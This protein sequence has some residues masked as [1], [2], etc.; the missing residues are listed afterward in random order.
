MGAFTETINLTP[1]AEKVTRTTRGSPPLGQRAVIAGGDRVFRWAQNGSVAL[2]V[3]RLLQESVIGSGHGGDLAVQAA[4]AI[5]DQTVSITNST[6][7]ITED[8]Y[9]FGYLWIDNEGHVYRIKSHPAE[10]TGSGTLVIT[11]EDDDFLRAALTTATS[12][13]GLRRNPYDEV[14]V[15]PTSPTGVPVGVTPV[16]VDA[17]AFFWAQSWGL[18]SVLTNGTP[19]VGLGVT[20]GASTAGSVD[21]QPLNSVNASGQE[22]LVGY[23][24]RVRA[25][26]EFSLIDLRI[27]P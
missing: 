21:V 20:A 25:T 24:S 27:A 26:G 8:Q 5:N 22:S 10:S 4:G 6:T 12:T 17:D 9:R 7:A 15:N 13:V 3:N 19:I 11:L 1:G 18:A 16:A 2:S 23:V 14:L